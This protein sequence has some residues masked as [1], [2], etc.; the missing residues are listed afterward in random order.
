MQAMD[1]TLFGTTTNGGTYGYE[2]FG[3]IFKITTSGNLTT[4]YSF[5][6]ASNGGS[7]AARLL[8]ATNG[9]FFG[10]TSGGGANYYGTFFQ[11]YATG[12]TLSVSTSGNGTVTSTDGIIS[13]PGGACSHIYPNNTQV[14]LNATA[15]EGWA[16][17]GWGGACGGTGACQVTMTQD[18]SVTASF[19]PFYTLSVNITGSGRV[20][21]TDGFIN[22]PGV[23]SHVYVSNSLVTLNASPAQGWSLSSWGGLEC[24][25]TDTCT[26]QVSQNQ[27][28]NVTF[29]QN[30]YTLTA[31]MSGQG[32][33]TSTDGFINCPG[34]CSHTY[35]SL[36]AVT[37]NAAPA[38]GNTG[39]SA[40]GAA[41]ATASAPVTSLYDSGIWV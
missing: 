1:G 20:S 38:Q 37:L 22:C 39:T 7:P 24:Y 10:L 6:N 14:T 2:P 18:Q 9:D 28:V 31:S 5:N 21:S 40:A 19:L 13:C 23:C 41:P 34:T 26:V 11:F 17:V 15:A 30:Y 16:F 35:L 33:I 29:T 27:T 4:L 25:G 3:T 8:Q 32:T 12:K 36:T